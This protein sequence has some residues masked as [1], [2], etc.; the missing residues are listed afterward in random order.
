[1][2]Q[3]TYGQQRSFSDRARETWEATRREA[4]PPRLAAAGVLALGAAAYGL[5]RDPA[6]RERLSSS[7]RDLSQRYGLQ[8]ETS[9]TA[10]SIAIN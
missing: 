10:S 2:E 8:R 7:V 9:P 4:T 1:M 6:R 3:Q 5:L